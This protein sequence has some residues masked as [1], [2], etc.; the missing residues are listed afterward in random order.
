MEKLKKFWGKLKYW[1]KGGIIGFLL[2]ISYLILFWLSVYLTFLFPNIDPDNDLFFRILLYPVL[3]L[4]ILPAMLLTIFPVC[5]GQSCLD[6]I[7]LVGPLISIVSL[8]LL[9][10]LIGF[11]IGKIKKK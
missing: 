8:S 11:I 3:M 4:G 1:Q 2:G 5:E 7:R 6:F 10:A 9:G